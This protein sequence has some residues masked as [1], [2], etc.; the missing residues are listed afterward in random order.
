M[1]N[2]GGIEGDFEFE[3]GYPM[4]QLEDG[5]DGCTGVVCGIQCRGII[6]YRVGGATGFLES[7][8]AIQGPVS[9]KSMG[10]GKGNQQRGDNCITERRKR[11][12]LLVIVNGWTYG[13]SALCLHC[14]YIVPALCSCVAQMVPIPVLLSYQIPMYQIP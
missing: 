3:S 2:L 7:G 1:V 4:Y 5:R 13:V 10:T 12:I 6:W 8:E 9:D 14:A 11:Y